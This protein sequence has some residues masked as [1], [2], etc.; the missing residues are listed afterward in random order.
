MESFE[1]HGRQTPGGG[2]KPKA[3]KGNPFFFK[4][5]SFVTK[6]AASEYQDVKLRCSTCM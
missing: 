4:S 3:L 2:G 5:E 1:L 6:Y